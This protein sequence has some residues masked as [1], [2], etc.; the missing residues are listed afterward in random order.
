MKM[1]YR[2]IF[3][4]LAFAL[5]LGFAA[6]P[7]RAQHRNGAPPPPPPRY[8]NGPRAQQYRARQQARAYAAGNHNPYQAGRPANGAHPPSTYQPAPHTN[9]AQNQGAAGAAG[10]SRPAQTPYENAAHPPATTTGNSVQNASNPNSARLPGQW[11]QKLGQMS[12][13][14]QDRFLQNNERFKSM[15]P[16]KQQQI[17]QNLQNYNRLSPTERNAMKDRAEIWNHLSAE[18]KNYVQ[19]T[20]LPKWQQMSPDRKQAV[21]DR[22]HT[23]Q[24]MTPE[25]RQKSLNDPQFMRGLNPDEQSVLRGLDQVRNPSNP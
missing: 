18:Q 16:E 11:S 5:L 14:Q 17:R 19:H 20:L 10:N 12:P 1:R 23:L 24:G 2:R 9:T 25:D 3:S 4:A 15:P 7:A 13:Q 6:Q 8:G 22:L 21:T